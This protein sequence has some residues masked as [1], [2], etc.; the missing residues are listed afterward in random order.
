[1]NYL[2]K[3]FTSKAIALYVVVLVACS[4]LFAGRW[5]PLLWIVF[6]LTE[7]IAFFYFSNFFTRTWADIS[8]NLFRNELFKT[9]LA[10]RISYVVFSYFFY[11][12][13]TD[14]PF[15]F[16]ARDSM[17]YHKEAVWIV[18]MFE[19]GDIQYYFK[20]YLKGV[21]DSGFTL[22]LG[23]IYYFSAKSILVARLINAFAG[24]W[25]CLLIYNIAKRNFGEIPARISAVLAMLLP[26]LIYYCGLHTKETIMVFFL[27]AF[28]ERA[29]FFIRQR[30]IKTWNL[31]VVIILGASLFFF[32]TVLAAAAWFALFSA[33]LFSANKL[34]GAARKSIYIAW[35]T[36]AALVVISGQIRTEVEGYVKDRNTNQ[37]AQME[38]YATTKGA[39][40]LAKYGTASIFMPMML[41]APFPTLVYIEDQPN[42]MMINGNI[43]TRNVYAFFVLIALFTLYKKKL[44]TE[45]ILV[46]ALLLTYLVILSLSG[47]ALSERFHMPAVP[48]L[49]ILAGYGITQMNNRN[50]K[51]YIP[52]LVVIGLVI[53][54]WN[55]F[56]LA[57]RGGGF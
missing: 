45:H 16:E 47:F 7:V 25:T 50:V 13:M 31:L 41:F 39:N 37:K 23:F 38:N 56:K 8:N 30:T 9:A 35:F 15:E 5:L 17:G 48:F 19:A 3:Y 34:I 12:F 14:H 49:L 10:I 32:R 20:E 18:D 24:A 11:I 52:Y 57:G 46:L 40:T 6:G 29:D 28:A 36:I 53:I 21:S 51:F 2:S 42:A 43:F 1:L 4:L 26:T 55:W 27:V 22:F 33:L 44:L 54:G